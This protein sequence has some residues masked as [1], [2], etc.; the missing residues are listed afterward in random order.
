MLDPAVT[1]IPPPTA[2]EGKKCTSG[3]LRS[4]KS[5]PWGPWGYVALDGVLHNLR[6]DGSNDMRFL[7]SAGMQVALTE[8]DNDP[9]P[10]LSLERVESLVHCGWPV[11]RGDGAL[12]SQR[13]R[14]VST[15][16]REGSRVRSGV[17][18]QRVDMVQAKSN[19]SLPHRPGCMLS[20]A[21][22]NRRR[23]HCT[24]PLIV[25]EGRFQSK[26]PSIT[27]MTH[28]EERNAHGTWSRGPFGQPRSVVPTPRPRCLPERDC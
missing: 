7:Q 27:S 19:S 20:M 14:I 11:P 24:D 4:R 18:R 28:G 17:G 22:F 26:E 15:S 9:G 12:W 13:L 21:H 23:C 3:A 1:L 2:S 8:A 16:F 5:L 25:I 6:P 10:K